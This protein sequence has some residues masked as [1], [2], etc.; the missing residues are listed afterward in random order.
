M[1]SDSDIF[2]GWSVGSHGRHF[3]VRQLRDAKIKPLIETF[4]ALEM[5]RF[6]EWCGHSLAR[7]H[8]RAGEPAIISGYLGRS[9]AFDRAIAKFCTAYADQND[10][11]YEIVRKAARAGRIKVA[12]ESGR[13]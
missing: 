5:T 9:D 8:A 2:L 6:A 11:D 12:S 13:E 4:G 3:Y 7:S 1:Q 10:R